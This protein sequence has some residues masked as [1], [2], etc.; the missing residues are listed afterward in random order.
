MRLSNP[1]QVSPRPR[2]WPWALA[3]AVT[4]AAASASLVVLLRRWLGED[5]VDAQ[6]PEDLQAVV[7]RPDLSGATGP[8]DPG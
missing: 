2:R 1:V 6:E 5:A 4:G 3:A 7:D 8:P